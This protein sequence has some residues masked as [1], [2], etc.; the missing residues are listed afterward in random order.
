MKRFKNIVYV[1][2]DDSQDSSSL[3]RVVSLAKNNQADLTLLKIEPK[4]SRSTYSEIVGASKDKIECILLKRSEEWLAQ[5]IN[6][7]DLP[8]VVTGIVKMGKVHEET[9]RLVQ[10][11]QFDL[12]IKDAQNLTWVERFFTSEDIN[13][14]RL[15]PTPVWLLKA[16]AQREYKNILAAVSFDDYDDLVVYPALNNTLIKLA[17]SMA[18]LESSSLHVANVYDAANAGF[19]GLW[20]EDPDEL[21]N[22][23]YNAEFSISSA[24]MTALLTALKQDLGEQAYSYLATKTHLIQGDPAQELVNL[25][26]RVEADLVV[27][28][29]TSKEGVVAA[30]LGNTV[31]TVLSQLNCSVLAVKP[32]GFVTPLVFD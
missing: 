8:T 18:L 23:L 12:V 6:T 28:G 31:E 14:L 25:A 2:N 3:A 29:T 15:C 11:H 24:K 26:Q 32:D 9:I 20:A 22:Q 4:L 19:I 10:T 27:I 13:L 7:I 5:L 21:A 30:L 17:S 16:N 1:V